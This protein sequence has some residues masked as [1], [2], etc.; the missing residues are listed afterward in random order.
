MK[1]IITLLL[2]IP[3]LS[4][5]LT[6]KD[7]KQVDGSSS[8]STISK[9]GQSGKSYKTIN[10]GNTEEHER[11]IKKEWSQDVVNDFTRISDFSH[12]FELRAK[13][14]GGADCSRGSYKGSYGRTE[15]Y[16]NNPLDNQHAGE[17]VKI[18]TP[19]HFTW[20]IV[21]YHHLQE[22]T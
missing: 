14:C 6:F 8:T 11:D 21:I 19:G 20:M 17:L 10:W 16:L 3:S 4:W 5:G 18:G 2:L 1:L 12:R 22:N 15:A 13:E 7:G 9:N